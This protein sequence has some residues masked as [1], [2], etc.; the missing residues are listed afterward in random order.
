M[1]L[2]YKIVKDEFANA[3][4]LKFLHDGLGMQTKTL[5]TM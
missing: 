1:S 5:I 3:T 2:K 4:I